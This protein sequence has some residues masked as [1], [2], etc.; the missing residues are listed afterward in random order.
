MLMKTG[1]RWHCTDQACQCQILVETGGQIEGLNPRCACGEIMEKNYTSY[2]SAY[3][4]FLRVEESAGLHA[5]L[6]GI[7]HA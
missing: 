7:S 1:E 2:A 5:T 4:D 3:L 6:P